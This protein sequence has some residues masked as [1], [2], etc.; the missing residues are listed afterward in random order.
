MMA[1]EKLPGFPKTAHAVLSDCRVYRYALYR[2]LDGLA[3]DA[4]EAA[5]SKP[6]SRLYRTTACFLLTNP[7]TADEESNDKTVEKVMKQARHLGYGRVS[8]VN[9][10]AYRETDS[11]RLPSLAASGVDL[12]GPD[13]DLHILREA[14]ASDVVICG[15]GNPGK[16]LDRDE[17]L[18]VLLKAQDSGLWGTLSLAERASKLYCMK[19]NQNGTPIHPLY[20]KDQPELIPFRL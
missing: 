16:L 11:T 15:W 9:A 2:S 19:Q 3:W 12:V 13:N 1:Q 4:V 10:F 5:G 20:Q 18:R 6:G 7:S 17:Q 14:A 8:M